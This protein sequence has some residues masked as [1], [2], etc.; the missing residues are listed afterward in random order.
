MLREVAHEGQNTQEINEAYKML[1]TVLQKDKQYEQA[2]AC[3]KKILLSAWYLN[4]K[5]WEQTALKH[6][7][8][9][10]FYLGE[11]SRARFYN[12]KAER[13]IVEADSSNNK[14][15]AK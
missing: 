6:L 12:E 11:I 8:I 4:D 3:F 10:F 2:L 14:V 7:A 5:K 15:V 1:G 9:Q 13:G